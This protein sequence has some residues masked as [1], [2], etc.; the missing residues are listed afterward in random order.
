[1]RMKGLTKQTAFSTPYEAVPL[2]AQGSGFERGKPRPPNWKL[3]AKVA[4]REEAG[5]RWCP[6]SDREEIWGFQASVQ[7]KRRPRH[8]QEALARRTEVWNNETQRRRL[9]K[10]AREKALPCE[11]QSD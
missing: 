4:E 11:D 1:M 8:Q 10:L 3:E 2:K 6:V 7:E 9:E 5:G